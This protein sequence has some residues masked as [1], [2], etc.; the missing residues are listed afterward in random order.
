MDTTSWQS[1]LS[2]NWFSCVIKGLSQTIEFVG[3]YVVPLEMKGVSATWYKVSDI[4]FHIRG[5]NICSKPIT[6]RLKRVWMY[7][8]GGSELQNKKITYKK[9]QFPAKGE[10]GD[11]TPPGWRACVGNDLIILKCHFAGIYSSSI[12]SDTLLKNGEFK[13]RILDGR[14]TPIKSHALSGRKDIENAHRAILILRNPFDTLRAE[15]KRR[16]VGKTKQL[17][18]V[19]MAGKKLAAIVFV[20]YKARGALHS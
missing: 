20:W 11:R 1:Y 5:N 17:K 14:A 7:Y 12:Y 19:N 10:G 16:R 13:A 18:K 9:D 8:K 2:R 15:F 6:R 4:P 3:L